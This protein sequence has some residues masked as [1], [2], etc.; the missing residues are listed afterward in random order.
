MQQSLAW[1]IGVNILTEFPFRVPLH[2]YASP[3]N[4]ASFIT[5]SL[6]LAIGW[7]AHAVLPGGVD[8]ALLLG[9]SLGSF[10]A[11][12]RV[13]GQLHPPIMDEEDHRCD[14]DHARSG[15]MFMGWHSVYLKLATSLA[16]SSRLI[17]CR[18]IVDLSLFTVVLYI[19]APLWPRDHPV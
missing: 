6:P 11:Q 2:S 3:V 10:A 4:S 8:T 7:P 9:I 19:W 18:E 13:Y 12:V 1:T 15:C 5:S 17:T 14:D 16:G